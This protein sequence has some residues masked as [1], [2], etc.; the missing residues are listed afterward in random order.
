MGVSGRIVPAGVQY[1][2]AMTRTGQ[3]AD[4]G[5]TRTRQPRCAG[6]GRVDAAP[7]D[8]SATAISTDA[9]SGA[10]RPELARPRKPV[11]ETRAPEPHCARQGDGRIERRLG[12]ADLGVG[13][14]HGTLDG[15]DVGPALEQLRRHAEGN[16]RQR[17]DDRRPR[18][19]ERRRRLTD[20]C[21][22]RMLELRTGHAEVD[23]LRL[24]ALQLHLRLDDVDL[25][26][27]A[28]RGCKRH[29]L[30]VMTQNAPITQATFRPPS[31]VRSAAKPAGC[32]GPPSRF[33]K[34]RKPVVGLFELGRMLPIECRQVV[35]SIVS[36]VS[37]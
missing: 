22:D 17:R 16:S 23:E 29:H 4:F 24:G 28:R 27:D 34:I 36:I 12:N 1:T 2:S 6:M 33:T 3:T 11:C 32:T 14:G 20:E 8:A 25:R 37:N 18:D 35:T 10:K 15:G 5:M 13:R 31:L 7:T 19:R 21:P 9:A 26:S 30:Q